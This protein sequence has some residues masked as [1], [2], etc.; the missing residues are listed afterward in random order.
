MKSNEELLV[1]V[2]E[3]Q[4][5]SWFSIPRSDTAFRHCFFTL[6]FGVF[7]FVAYG[8][9]S[10][11]SGLIPYR[12]S[13]ELP[14]E[15]A[16]PYVPVASLIYISMVAMLCMAPFLLRSWQQMWV[17][18]A[19]LVVETL[20]GAAFF[21]VLPVA[22][23]PAIEPGTGVFA[24]VYVFAEFINMERNEFPSLHVAFAVTAA[25]TYRQAH[26]RVAGWV[27]GAWSAAIVASTLFMKE[28]Y[29]LDVV[30]G[31]LLAWLVWHYSHRRF[32]SVAWVASVDIELIAFREMLTFSRRH[33]RYATIMIAIYFA[34][35]F[36]WRK[37][38]ILRTGFTSLQWIDDLL[39]H[40]RPAIESPLRTAQ[41][42]IDQLGARQQDNSRLGRL[43]Y[44]MAQDLSDEGHQVA[45]RLI[46]I[47]CEDHKRMVQSKLMTSVQ[48]QSQL[49][50]T[51]SCSFDIF[52]H[53]TNSKL[54]S[55]EFPDLIQALSWCSVERD[56]P[57]DL[58]RGLINIP[59]EVVNGFSVDVPVKLLEVPHV[60]RWRAEQREAIVPVLD[61]L[62]DKLSKDTREGIGLL[63]MFSRSIRKYAAN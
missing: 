29:L 13:V 16:I 40:D 6:L 57:E 63:R 44:S 51:F 39:D 26:G 30:A 23:T 27:F 37:R 42:A 36:G 28:H 4:S 3:S 60:Q 25:L 46:E 1:G 53:A 18:F 15:A 45:I 14:F 54:R 55:T 10:V 34:S 32:S 62:D 19:V 56:L 38:R 12:M 7:F 50:Q 22:Q 35:L 49:N 61:R 17:L 11:I 8:G 43:V 59:A 24:N 33:R 31:V 20:V 48:I 47:M 41:R 52:M 58:Q 21:I 9:A 2:R 5:G